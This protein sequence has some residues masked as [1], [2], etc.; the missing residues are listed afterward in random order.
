MPWAAYLVQDNACNPDIRIELRI[1]LQEGCSASGHAVHINYQDYRQVKGFCNMRGT[2]NLCRVNSVKESH[3][4]FYY[5]NICICGCSG[6]RLPN[7]VSAHH[8]GVKIP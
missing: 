1:S 4:S 8:V 6:Y 7:P 5:N 3:N 2:C